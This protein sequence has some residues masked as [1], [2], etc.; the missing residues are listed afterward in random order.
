MEKVWINEN[1]ETAANRRHLILK[2]IFYEYIIWNGCMTN[3]K[4]FNAQFSS[5]IIQC[6]INIVM[7]EIWTMYL[8]AC[9]QGFWNDKHRFLTLNACIHIHYIK[10][11]AI[12]LVWSRFYLVCMH[13]TSFIGSKIEQTP[14]GSGETPFSHIVW[15][16]Y[17]PW[18]Y[19]EASSGSSF[20]YKNSALMFGTSL[21]L[22][23]LFCRSLPFTRYVCIWWRVS[24]KGV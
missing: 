2:N 20:N 11:V 24:E 22:C 8:Y 5:D 15:K 19:Q 13:T 3:F 17:P 7:Q 4:K 1:D 16:L 6:I 21:V 9:C 12:F 18:L 10:S 23:N 14:S